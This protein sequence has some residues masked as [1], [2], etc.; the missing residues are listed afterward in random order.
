[1]PDKPQRAPLTV[2]AEAVLKTP[3][4]GLGQIQVLH[5]ENQK[6]LVSIKVM[7]K[8][9]GL[10]LQKEMALEVAT[11]LHGL[12]KGLGLLPPEVT[13]RPEEALQ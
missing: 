1:M 13:A 4:G 5:D 3:Q 6:V 9:G 2:I 8:Q 7:G 10:F 12:L 11:H